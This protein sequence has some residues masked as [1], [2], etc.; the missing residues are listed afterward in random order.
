M[1]L[2]LLAGTPRVLAGSPVRADVDVLHTFCLCRNPPILLRLS[3]VQL[4]L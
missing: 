1:V 2:E 3:H 4:P